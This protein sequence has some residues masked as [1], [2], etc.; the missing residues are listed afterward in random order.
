MTIGW[1]IPI[2]I[3]VASPTMIPV[4][5]IIE[6]LFLYQ[7]ANVRKE[8]YYL[9]KTDET[10]IQITYLNRIQEEQTNKSVYLLL[11]IFSMLRVILPSFSS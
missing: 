7:D 6:I 4:K 5:F 11:L 2:T 10:D 1:N 9:H 8:N 3:N